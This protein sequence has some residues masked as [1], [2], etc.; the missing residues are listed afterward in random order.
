MDGTVSL[1]TVLVAVAIAVAVVF[2]YRLGVEV[3]RDY[4]RRLR[5]ARARHPVG[6]D[7]QHYAAPSNVIPIHRTK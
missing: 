3:G 2:A 5:K 6:R 1:T 7:L 4:E